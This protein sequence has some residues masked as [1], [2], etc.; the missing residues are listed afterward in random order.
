MEGVDGIV[1]SRVA[2]WVVAFGRARFDLSELR[3]DVIADCFHGILWWKSSC[4]LVSRKAV[5][6]G[7]PAI[8][9]FLGVEEVEWADTAV[10]QHV[11]PASPW[12]ELGTSLVPTSDKYILSTFCFYFFNFYFEL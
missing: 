9:C 10:G 1:R 5:F 6:I 12:H 8:T 11:K 2:P 3:D 4:L 7:R